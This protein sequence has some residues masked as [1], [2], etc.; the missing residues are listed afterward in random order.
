MARTAVNT[1]LG[2]QPA[3]TGA[4]AGCVVSRKEIWFIAGSLR[5]TCQLYVVLLMRGL[6]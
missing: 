3:A 6:K 4:W 5:V 2:V 1:V